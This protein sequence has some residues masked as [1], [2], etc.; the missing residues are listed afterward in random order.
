[1]IKLVSQWTLLLYVSLLMASI[2]FASANDY[3]KLEKLVKEKKYSLAFQYASK[4]RSQNEG[5]PRFDYL[6]G[7]SALQSGNYNEAVFALDRVTVNSPNVIRPRLEL[8]RA[9]LSLNNSFAAKKEFNDVL[10]L[11]PPPVVRK[12]VQ[13][14]LAELEKK[15][16]RITQRS[17][18]KS[19]ASL[20]FGYDDNINFGYDNAEIDLPDFGVV[21]LND[22]SVKQGSGFAEGKFQFKHR[23]LKNK[24]KSTFFTANATHREYFKNSDFNVTDLDLRTGITFNHAK[25]QYQLVGRTRPVMLGG[26]LY[27]NTI[28]VDAIARKSIGSSQVGSLKLS[29]EKYDNK[30]VTLSD[31]SRAIVSGR[32]DKQVGDTQH[33]LN[34]YLGKEWPD[35]SEG[36][37]YSRNISGIGY[38]AV[39]EWNKK[40]RTYLGL[41]YRHYK[42]QQAYAIYDNKRSDDRFIF[43]VGHE[44]RFN[45]ELAFVAQARHINNQ[46]NLDL[47]DAK[48]NEVKVGIRYDWD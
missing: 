1:M 19:L 26:E 42:H 33:Q 7:F 47:Y 5:D 18:T 24:V 3:P 25:K 2:T 17:V 38:W 8:A 39:K 27:S 40:D 4:I 32:I 16:D 34:L 15:G 22:S 14:Y 44:H 20:S 12:K 9:Y 10:N 45:D 31:R 48:R 43:K 36:K 11:N 23:T 21:T 29:I 35:K 41:D 37:Q 46:S 6:Y 13:A 30:K 28:G